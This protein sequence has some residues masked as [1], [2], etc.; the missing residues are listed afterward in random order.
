MRPLLS[1]M[2]VPLLL[3]PAAGGAQSPATPVAA[4]DVFLDCNA[5][6]CESSHIR[7]EI[8]YVN[9]VRDRTVAD[10]HLLITSQGTGSGGEEY[11]LAYVG[12]GPFAGDSTTIRL[13][14]EQ[15]ATD[16]ERRDRVT[17]RIAQGLM[18]YLV[19]T[20]AADA[21]EIA[22]VDNGDREDGDRG[23]ATT[24]ANDPWNAWVFSIGFDGSMEGEAR[25]TEHEISG[26]LSASRVTRDWKLEFELEGDYSRNRFEL[27]DGPFVS[28]TEDWNVEAF[29]ARSV[30]TLWSAG[31]EMRAGTSTF[32]N[33]EF[34]VRIA[35]ALEYS[36]FP[37]E[38]F[39][40]RQITLRYS[41]GANQW[42]YIEETLYGFMNERR[43]D[44]ELA[45]DLE[46]RQ[47]W[48]SARANLSGSHYLHDVQ[49]YRASIGGGLDIRLI[50]GLSLD[51]SGSYSRVHDQLYVEGG[52]DLTDEE[53]LL[54]L[55]SLQTNYEYE[56]RLG[57]RYTFGSVF[58][59][60]VNP[61]LGRGDFDRR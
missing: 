42:N 1:S 57:L 5:R 14:T 7:N 61:R 17:A 55:R 10:V 48:G 54:R 23:P 50:R 18:R 52:D 26:E 4:L 3:A 39:S 60:I 22:M 51:V 9:W 59:N 37:Y 2:L 16:S 24:P 30:S 41:V 45:L 29:M 46:F 43:W 15:T 34:R 21:V 56:T 31:L 6:N 36:I 47:L 28:T 19:H 11:R 58:N 32:E 25:E 38:E 44:Q 20:A 49:K 12:L 53:I 13:A 27:S 8:T 35:P 33:Q 40:R